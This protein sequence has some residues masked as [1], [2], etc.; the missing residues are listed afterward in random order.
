MELQVIVIFVIGFV[1]GW[2]IHS[3]KITKR[4][5]EDPEHMIQML[6]SYKKAK[7]NLENVSSWDG[8]REVIVEKHGPMLYI[9]AK[10]TN[11]FLAQGPTLQDALDI[12]EKRFPNQTFKGLISKEDAAKMEIKT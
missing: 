7:I 4:I 3:W 9:F 5:L 12:L 10:D 8:T 2:Y 11:E 6:E 1:F